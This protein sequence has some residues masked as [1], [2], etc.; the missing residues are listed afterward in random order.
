MNIFLKNKYLKVKMLYHKV[1]M[2]SVFLDVAKIFS[3]VVVSTSLVWI[4]Y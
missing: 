1:C 3:K 4:V 2:F